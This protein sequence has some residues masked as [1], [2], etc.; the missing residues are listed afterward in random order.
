MHENSAKTND[1]LSINLQEVLIWK[2]YVAIFTPHSTSSVEQVEEN[3]Y[4]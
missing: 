3:E 4:T 1:K 2:G